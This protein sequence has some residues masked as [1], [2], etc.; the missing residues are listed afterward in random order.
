V[1]VVEHD[2]PKTPDNIVLGDTIDRVGVTPVI[3]ASTHAT[4][5]ATAPKNCGTAM[6]GTN[7]REGRGAERPQHEQALIVVIAL[8]IDRPA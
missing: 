6:Q 2:V 8:R 1:I 7:G 4:A 5:I 3:R